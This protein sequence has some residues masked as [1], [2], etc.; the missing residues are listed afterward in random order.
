MKDRYYQLAESPLWWYNKANDLHASAGVLWISMKDAHRAIITEEIG[1]SSGFDL[2]VA[3]ENVCYMLL[4]LSFELLF[5]SIIVAK[6]CL[7]KPPNI[8]KLGELAKIAEFE[9]T[10]KEFGIISVLSSY[11][12]WA[13]KY[14]VPKKKEEYD[15]DI[16]NM[17]ETLYDKTNN[18]KYSIVEYNKVLEWDKLEP[19]WERGCKI[20]FE[21]HKK[22]K[23][24]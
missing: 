3:C 2:R 14:P 5:K 15:R 12:V 8:H 7:V 24:H 22:T 20:F 13:G 16:Q 1:L 19:I 9:I 4:G 23:K 11:I 18:K 21:R 10:N 6:D 17:E